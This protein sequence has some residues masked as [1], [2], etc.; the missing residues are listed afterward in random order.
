MSITQIGIDGE[1][2]ARQIISQ[3]I[4]PEILFQAD[5]LFKHKGNWILTEVKHKERFVGTR[6]QYTGFQGHGLDL[7]QVKA[8]TKFYK[9][10]GIRCFF[11]VI[12]IP[13]NIVFCNWLDVLEDKDYITTKNQI[14]I[15]NIDNFTQI[16]NIC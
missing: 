3:Y 4:K 15:Y 1:K 16:K 5:W 8:R 12:E 14:R 11:I 6:G 2:M 13:S 10:T 7:R 9:E